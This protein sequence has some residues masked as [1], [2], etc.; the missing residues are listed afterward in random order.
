MYSDTENLKRIFLKTDG[1]CH[2]SGQR[3]CFKNYGKIGS[4]GAW[5][6]DHSR[7]QNNGGSHHLN[8]LY[9]AAITANRSKQARSSRSARTDWGRTRAPLSKAAQETASDQNAWQGAAAGAL[10]GLSFGPV[11]AFWGGVVGLVV[12]VNVPVE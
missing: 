1:R 4:R 7:A 8:N 9:P 10:I 2:L 6:I 5:E 3:L 12:G 11:G